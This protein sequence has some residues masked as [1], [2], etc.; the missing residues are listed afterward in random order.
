MR[1][2]HAKL[3]RSNAWRPS[4]EGFELTNSGEMRCFA[5]PL[6]YSSGKKKAAPWVALELWLQVKDEAPGPK[7]NWKT[8]ESRA[9]SKPG[10]MEGRLLK[11]WMGQGV[12]GSMRECVLHLSHGT[13]GKPQLK[14]EDVE[15][16]EA[17]GRYKAA[18]YR[19]RSMRRFEGNADK[20]DRGRWATITTLMRRARDEHVVHANADGSVS[21]MSSRIAGVEAPNLL[22]R[23]D[24]GGTRAEAGRHLN[25]MFEF[26]V[27]TAN[28]K[29]KKGASREG[30]V[31]IILR[32]KK[33]ET[34]CGVDAVHTLCVRRL[35]SLYD[36]I[37]SHRS[38]GAKQAVMDALLHLNATGNGTNETTS[39]RGMSRARRLLTTSANDDDDAPSARLEGEAL[40][41]RLKGAMHTVLA[42][43]KQRRKGGLDS[44]KLRPSST[45]EGRATAELDNVATVLADGGGGGEA[46][47]LQAQSRPS[48]DSGA[49]VPQSRAASIYSP[50]GSFRAPPRT[51]ARPTR[52]TGRSAAPRGGRGG[53]VGLIRAGA[54]HILRI[55][56]VGDE[57]T[58]KTS[59]A[60]SFVTHSPIAARA[61]VHTKSE[62]AAADIE[63][64]GAADG[65][66]FADTPER[67]VERCAL[68]SLASPVPMRAVT[69]SGSMQGS[70]ACGDGAVHTLRF[71]IQTRDYIDC[72]RELTPELRE[73]ALDIT[74]A[75]TVRE[76]VNR[77]A[78]AKIAAAYRRTTIAP[79]VQ[80]LPKVHWSRPLIGRLDVA[81]KAAESDYDPLAYV[82]MLDH[83]RTTTLVRARLFRLLSSSCRGLLHTVYPTLPSPPHPPP[84]SEQERAK[85]WCADVEKIVLDARPHR[86]WTPIVFFVNFV[87]EVDQPIWDTASPRE[88]S[89]SFPMP[90]HTVHAHTSSSYLYDYCTSLPTD[91]DAPRTDLR[92]RSE[93]RL[94]SSRSSKRFYANAARAT[95]SFNQVYAS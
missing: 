93:L 75:D 40:H 70:Y 51:N 45:K 3:A 30:F 29:K 89:V 35:E 85:V 14:L 62:S 55:A 72:I 21:G 42:A 59:L 68:P 43:S 63:T 56:I 88:E 61:A 20:S 33:R 47:P 38:S 81:L 5:S 50:L 95:T 71:P 79:A 52:P 10:V 76:I 91:T 48:S 58:G 41:L 86:P 32:P 15:C 64:G 13:D 49:T 22:W 60:S 90:T 82:V 44:S 19:L 54:A 80:K 8:W 57:K 74:P 92:S 37:R 34:D 83:A 66:S 23:A 53:S 73:S 18:E 9:Q 36:R 27:K 25:L 16:D 4:V 6:Y 12:L 77:G 46:S 24:A 69:F 31:I 2:S 84:H 67:L 87:D 65:L 17:T 1:S 39:R 7:K 94:L 78:F 11:Q 28:S 26:R